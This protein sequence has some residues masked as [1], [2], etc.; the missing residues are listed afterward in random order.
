[1]R[2]DLELGERS[3]SNGMRSLSNQGQESGIRRGRGGKGTHILS[4]VSSVPISELQGIALRVSQ[5]PPAGRGGSV[6]Q[7]GGCPL[8]PALFPP[9]ACRLALTHRTPPSAQRPGALPASREVIHWV[10]RGK[11]LRKNLGKGWGGL[12]RGEGGDPEVSSGVDV[13]G[14]GWVTWSSWMS[15]GIASRIWTAIFTTSRG[16]AMV[17]LSRAAIPSKP[18]NLLLNAQLV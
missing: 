14:R 17:Q 3:H 9:L 8:P 6:R 1:M 5:A 13:G 4:D 12:F 2:K 15:C 10:G 18:C 7:I 11:K 16:G